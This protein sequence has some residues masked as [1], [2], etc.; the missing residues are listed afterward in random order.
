MNFKKVFGAS[1][2]IASI[3]QM[4]MMIFMSININSEQYVFW[5]IVVLVELVSSLLMLEIV[6][7]S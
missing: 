2:L 4:Y 5:F 7:Y 6:D 3:F 1:I